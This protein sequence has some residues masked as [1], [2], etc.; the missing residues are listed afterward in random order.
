LNYCPGHEEQHNDDGGLEDDPAGPEASV[1]TMLDVPGLHHMIDN[2]TKGLEAVQ[3]NYKDCVT[4]AQAVCKL[5]HRRDTREKLLAR[6]FNCNIGRQFHSA[7]K[8]FK[9]KIHTG[10]WGT[11][12][13]SV[14]ELLNIERVLRW[15]WDKEKYRQ[16][17]NHKDDDEDPEGAAVLVQ[18]VD[19]A[20]SSPF[21]WAWLR[22]PGK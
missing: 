14:L 11:V 15:G 17:E 20:V 7:I 19:D 5:V 13:F 16:G 8:D 6:C 10:R 1:D 12:A 3:E 9:G 21:F 18:T 22:N 4:K 2:A